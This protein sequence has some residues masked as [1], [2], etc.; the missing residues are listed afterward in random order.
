MRNALAL[1]AILL[2]APVAARPAESAPGAMVVAEAFTFVPG[3]DNV[4]GGAVPGTTGPVA[5]RQGTDLLFLN[6]EIVVLD[7]HSITSTGCFSATEPCWFDSSSPRPQA[8]GEYAV[9]ETHDLPPGTYPFVCVV[10][11]VMRGTVVVV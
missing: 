8:L 7:P 5:L 4:A 10:H 6:L 11:P 3:G 9:V 1:V 2:A